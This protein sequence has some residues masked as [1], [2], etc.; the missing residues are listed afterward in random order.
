MTFWHCSRGLPA[1]SSAATTRSLICPRPSWWSASSGPMG[2]TSLTV[3]RMAWETKGEQLAPS[4]IR[5]R[6][7]LSRVLASSRPWRSCSSMSFV[8]IMRGTSEGKPDLVHYELGVSLR[9]PGGTI[10][11]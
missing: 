10:R 3:V 2:K 9:M 11:T 1:G 5:R 7:M 4:S 6:N 8:R